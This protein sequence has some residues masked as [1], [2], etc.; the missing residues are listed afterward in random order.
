[1][2]EKT[3][4]TFQSENA[5]PDRVTETPAQE[6]ATASKS[7]VE[8]S[9][10]PQHLQLIQKSGIHEEVMR[11]RGYRSVQSAAELKRLGFSSTQALTPTLL[12]PLYS[13]LNHT[14]PVLHQHR[15]DDPRMIGDKQTKYETP[16]GS[17]MVVDAH[18]LIHEMLR[19][20]R[21]PLFITEGVRK[22]DAAISRGM[23]CIALIGVWNWRGT[24]EFGG[25]TALADWDVIAFKGKDTQGKTFSRKMYLTFDSDVVSK[26]AVHE[27]MK[28]FGAFATGKGAE[29]AYTY[30]PSKSDGSKNGLDDFL[31][32]GHSM[33]DVIA[34]SQK[35]LRP[36]LEMSRADS[37]VSEVWSPA[38]QTSSLQ[39]TPTHCM[40]EAT[41]HG[42]VYNKETVH[43]V[44]SVRLTN[45]T[46]EI[47]AEIIED[48]GAETTKT[49]EIGA[50]LENRTVHVTVPAIEFTTLN[51]VLSSLGARAIVHAGQGIK[52]HTRVAIQSVSNHIVSRRIYKHTGWRLLETGEWVYL[53]AGGAIGS[54]TEE[55]IE[56]RLTDTLSYYNLPE[57]PQGRDLHN[58]VHALL[59]LAELGPKDVV[60]PLLAVI[61]RSAICSA[62]FSLHVAGPSGA[63]KSELAALAQQSFGKDFSSRHLPAAW[64]STDNALEAAAFCA[65]D[66]LFV[67]DDFVPRGSSSDIERLNAKADRLL[68]GQGNNAG[69]QRLRSDSTLRATRYPRGL[70][71]STGEDI[72]TG[73]SLRGRMLILEVAL[74][75]INADLLLACQKDAADGLYA[76]ALS[77][78]ISWL[79]PQY[80]NHL[81]T[82]RSEIPNIRQY[83]IQQVQ[84]GQH[85]RAPD[86]VANLMAGFRL[87]LKFTV[88]RGILTQEQGGKWDDSMWSALLASARKQSGHQD[89]SEPAQRFLELLRAVLA[90]GK[91]H[92]T[93]S[94][95]SRPVPSEGWGWREE[96]SGMEKVWKP[97]GERIG[98]IDGDDIYLIPDPTYKAV[99]AMGGNIGEGISISASSLWKRVK[100]KGWLAS[101]DSKR[102][103]NTIRRVFAR[104]QANVLHFHAAL[105]MEG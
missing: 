34:L 59:K 85:R 60:M 17:R 23:C 95:G 102:G 28:R 26:K 32:E 72:P 33:D 63:F 36:F 35:E 100:E 73:Q 21:I 19:D 13:P 27:A 68:R 101:V 92:L 7:V 88:E 8:Y 45:F 16:Q 65:K 29:V 51:W 70:I 14:E 64:S 67:V 52:D 82:L 62:D 97:Q 84:Q 96:Q 3:P 49:L 91:V 80:P 69:R 50:R 41:E 74:G 99:C 57:P 53:H 40:Y 9:L 47:E 61:C 104:M 78:F 31:S 93:D 66:A 87:F 24:N 81:Q 2:D 89:A 10:L 25:L 48:D 56:V 55:R 42:L 5:P 39:N 77:G 58:A 46:A 20:P 98:W 44:Q 83:V 6:P 71:L 94:E 4:L 43:G 79:A 18:P 76:Q 54:E 30:L 22:A 1:M 15:P 37:R 103:T 38:E 105:F 86:I 90:A 11:T 12:I 75:D